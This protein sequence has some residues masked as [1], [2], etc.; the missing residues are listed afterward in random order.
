MSLHIQRIIL[1]IVVAVCSYRLGY[2]QAKWKLTQRFNK[3][4]DDNDRQS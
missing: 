3:A 2:A 4:G 1:L